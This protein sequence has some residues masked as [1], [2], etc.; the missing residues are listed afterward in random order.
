MRVLGVPIA[1]ALVLVTGC[2]GGSQSPDDPPQTDAPA[3]RVERRPGERLIVRVTSR[4][5]AAS[6]C[7][8]LQASPPPESA[9]GLVEILVGDRVVERCPT[10]LISESS[11][12]SPPI[13]EP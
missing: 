5:E 10:E 7:A 8:R 2:G 3:G 11:I 13:G 4:D 1:V 12:S 9:G 6:T